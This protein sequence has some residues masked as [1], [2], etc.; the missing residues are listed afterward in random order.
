MQSVPLE[1]C[2]SNVN[3]FHTYVRFQYCFL[4]TESHYFQILKQNPPGHRL[5]QKHSP[6]WLPRWARSQPQTPALAIT[7]RTRI[8]TMLITHSTRVRLHDCNWT[9]RL[10]ASMC[11]VRQDSAMLQIT[12]VFQ[13]SHYEFLFFSWLLIITKYDFTN[14][15]NKEKAK[16]KKNEGKFVFF[17]HKFP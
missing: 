1:T 16:P 13:C 8:L 5:P 2:L 14:Q 7:F 6:C 15:Q 9:F 4:S 17:C 3:Q 11:F 10:S 12:K